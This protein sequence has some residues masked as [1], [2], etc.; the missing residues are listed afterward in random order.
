MY[1]GRFQLGVWLDAYLQCRTSS[2]LPVM[3][4]YVPQIRIL[5]ASDGTAV[6]NGLMP[7]VD[8]TSNIGLFCSRLFLGIGF[9]VGMHS[10][11][12]K[13]FA[14]QPFIVERTFEIIGAGDPKGNVLAMS[15]LHTPAA[16]HIV[17]QTEAGL[18]IRGKNPRVN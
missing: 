3:P 11:S 8:K 18:I 5:R 12:M 2:R 9:S 1:L 6:Y 4:S 15:Y 13:Y 10:V 16:D 14:S 7:V 17:Y